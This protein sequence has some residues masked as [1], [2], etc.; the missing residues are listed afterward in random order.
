[1][2]HEAHHAAERAEKIKN[3]KKRERKNKNRHKK[4][5]TIH[6]QAVIGYLSDAQRTIPKSEFGLSTNGEIDCMLRNLEPTMC[7]RVAVMLGYTYVTKEYYSRYDKRLDMK[8][9]DKNHRIL[10][11]RY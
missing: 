7:R 1:M 3:S 8:Q 5:K 10:M 11:S 6:F 4:R 9:K 2:G